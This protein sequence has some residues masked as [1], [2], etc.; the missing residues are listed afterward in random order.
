MQSP[1]ASNVFHRIFSGS[2]A[3]QAA[4]K[5]PISV[6]G[7]IRRPSQSQHRSTKSEG[8]RPAGGKP[9]YGHEPSPSLARLSTSQLPRIIYTPA[10]PE[11]GT[12][13]T[14]SSPLFKTP[15]ARKIS[16]NST[17]QGRTIGRKGKE[18]EGNGRQNLEKE[19]TVFASHGNWPSGVTAIAAQRSGS[20]A[21]EGALSS[22]TE[23]NKHLERIG[24]ERESTFGPGLAGLGTLQREISLKRGKE[25]EEQI[26]ARD[27]EQKKLFQQQRKQKNEQ[28]SSQE[29]SAMQTDHTGGSTSTV[30]TTHTS[31]WGRA[32]G[33]RSIL[34]GK[35]GSGSGLP[36]LTTR[37]QH[38]AFAFE[39]PVPCSTSWSTS[40][41]GVPQ[42]ISSS[43][44]EKPNDG[45]LRPNT[46]PGEERRP[47]PAPALASIGHRSGLKG[48]SLDLGL[49]LAWAPS[50]VREEALLPS[51]NVGR[52]FSQTSSV[53]SANASNS[54]G[55]S[56]SSNANGDAKKDANAEEASKLGKEVAAVFKH[57]LDRDG[58]ANFRRYVQQFD[59]HEIPFDGP[60]GIIA[61]VEQLLGESST[62]KPQE[63]RQLMDQLVRI[64][65]R[66]A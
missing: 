45:K 31:S 55:K 36:K 57:T 9:P 5:A 41:T 66:N 59:A 30:G 34:S 47:L 37:T 20:G 14:V 35:T 10:T 44:G 52:S 29:E 11:R 25:R 28:L 22:A 42:E 62:L 48:R 27:A 26:R 32:A 33:K 7:P 40:T 3:I 65:L 23:W 46:G 49:G 4:E 54:T 24:Q 1:G 2:K 8:Q 43:S 58:F 39:P 38:P 56:T 17:N 16:L 50:T 53:R 21:T 60:T 51:F 64:I 6:P 12:I 15:D 61:R 19:D 63:K 18:R 13:A